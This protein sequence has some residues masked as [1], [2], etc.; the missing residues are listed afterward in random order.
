MVAVQHLNWLGT[1]LGS[2]DF[3][4]SEFSHYEHI[5]AEHKIKVSACVFQYYA[6][7]DAIL[8]AAVYV[9]ANAVFATLPIHLFSFWRK[10]QLWRLQKK[11]QQQHCHLYTL[12]EPLDTAIWSQPVHISTLK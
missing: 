5:A 8:D 11:L 10:F 7:A 3:D 2:I 9:R 6:L 1:P 12:D 4:Q